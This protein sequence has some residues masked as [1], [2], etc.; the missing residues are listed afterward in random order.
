MLRSQSHGWGVLQRPE[1][2]GPIV[3]AT[4]STLLPVQM[5]TEQVVVK[6]GPPV[7]EKI[8]GQTADYNIVNRMFIHLT[9]YIAHSNYKGLYKRN[10][11]KLQMNSVIGATM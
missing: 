4:H 7:M 11:C 2:Q 9:I 10:F 3:S 8:R 5:V 6:W 1:F